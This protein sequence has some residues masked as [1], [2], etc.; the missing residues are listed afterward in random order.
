MSEMAKDKRYIRKVV[1]FWKGMQS[2]FLN[3]KNALFFEQDKYKWVKDVR[4]RL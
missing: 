1:E 3:R 2:I 4:C